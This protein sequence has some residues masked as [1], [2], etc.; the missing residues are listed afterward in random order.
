MVK[1]VIFD[2]GGTLLGA[3]DLFENILAGNISIEAHDDIYNQ[4]GKEFFRQIVDCRNGARFKRVGEILTIAIDAVNREKNNC[5]SL[6]NAEQVYWNTFVRDSF[7]I[8]DADLALGKLA[9]KKVEL[10]VASDADA[11]LIYAQFEKH[12]WSSYFRQSFISS[13]VEAYK[14]N[15]VFVAALNIAISNYEKNEVIFVGDSE[16]D[17]ETGKKLGVRTALISN[18]HQKQYHEDYSIGSLLELLDL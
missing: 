9:E 1:A 13:E 15:D 12:Q 16:V 4:L 6:V 2:V 14:P 3:T 7:V 17:I 11:A 10:L 8:H 18:R 5:L